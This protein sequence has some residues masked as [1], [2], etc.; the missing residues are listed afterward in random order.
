MAGF[1]LLHTGDLHGRLSDAAAEQIRELKQNSSSAL[2]LDAGDAVSAGNVG[3]RIRGEEVLRRM[4]RIGYNALS[5][6]NR[7]FHP[8]PPFLRKKIAD[9]EF[10]VLCANLIDPGSV[11][12]K[13]YQI[14]E[15]AGHRIAIFGLCVAMITP[16]KWAKWIS[17]F[18][19]EP[20]IDA[21]KRLVLE[22]RH[23]AS[24]VIALTHIGLK[25][26]LQLAASVPGI[27]LILGG[28]SHTPQE[29]PQGDYPKVL[30]AAYHARDIG[31]AELEFDS[32]KLKLISWERIP[33][34][35]G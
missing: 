17:P 10:P 3:V 25:A 34:N 7:E 18:L 1:T 15:I 9:A 30:H 12:I 5:M 31:K 8:W 20:P 26:D 24:Y 4:N 11:P 35:G 33:L 32:G 2:L 27:D 28:H 22:L 23:Q 13:P 6:G 21:A 19:F 29:S 16:S 14:F